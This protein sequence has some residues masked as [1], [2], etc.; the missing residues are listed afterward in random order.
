MVNT[1]ELS[2]LLLLMM[3]M[4][5]LL[6]TTTMTM[7][8]MMMMMMQLNQIGYGFCRGMTQTMITVEVGWRRRWQQ[9]QR[10]KL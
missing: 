9:R 8:M 6:M 5:L 3:M 2:M 7:M 1:L 10:Q 4:L